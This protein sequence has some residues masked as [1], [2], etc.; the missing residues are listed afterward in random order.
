MA[1]YLPGVTDYIPNIQ[2][3]RP[4][5]NFYQ[6]ALETKEA[7][8]KA[9][10][11]KISGLYG[12]LLN[13]E[14]TRE[15]NKQK[16]E[17]FFKNVQND[18]QRMATVDLSLE[19]NVN[20]AYR[21]FQPIIDDK[22]IT[23]DIVYTKQYYNQKSKGQQ[24]KNCTDPKK[25]GDAKWW[26]EGDLEM[27]Y[28]RQ[29]YAEADDQTA[30]TMNAPAYTP[31][32]DVQKK[33]DAAAKE[34]GIEVQSVTHTRDG[35]NI[36]TTNGQQLVG[37]LKNY[38]T[39][40]IMNDPLAQGMY[41]TKA[42]LDRKNFSFERAQE[43]GSKEAAEKVYLQDKIRII[44]DAMEH[45]KKQTNVV[46]D[47]LSSQIKFADNKI[48]TE[49]IPVTKA[50]ETASAL[51]NLYAQIEANTAVKDHL[52]ATTASIE[53]NELLGLD[54]P[55]MIARVDAAV[56][57]ASLTFDMS[58]Y[59]QNYADLH[60]KVTKEADPYD[61][62]ARE[63]LYAKEMEELK[64]L[65]DKENIAFKYNLESGADQIGSTRWEEV[66]PAAGATGKQ[67]LEAI[68]RE[69]FQS[70][71]VQTRDAG[72]NLVNSTY[73]KLRSF[74]DNGTPAERESARLSL[75]SIFG[76]KDSKSGY[77]DENYKLKYA[78]IK[79]NPGIHNIKSY[80]NWENLYK[81]ALE[82]NK[83][84]SI[85]GV[86]LYTDQHIS[87]LNGLESN[88]N[89]KKKVRDAVLDTYNSDRGKVYDYIKQFGNTKHK[90]AADIAKASSSLNEFIEGYTK[91]YGDSYRKA[92]RDIVP[93]A[94]E[95]YEEIQKEYSSTYAEN[96]NQMLSSTR[97]SVSS[98]G[99]GIVAAG[100]RTLFDASKKNVENLNYVNSIKQD[101]ENPKTV[102]LSGTNEA[103]GA[104]DTAK[105]AAESSEPLKN[106][107]RFWLDQ[108]TNR[109]W[110]KGEPG[111]DDRPI[112]QVTYHDI[113]GSDANTAA[114]EFEFN[115]GWANKEKGTVKQPGTSA[116][117]FSEGVFTPKVTMYVDKSTA[118]NLM[119]LRSKPDDMDILVQN[120]GK[121]VVDN[122]KDF[123]G[124]VTI[125]KDANGLKA[126][127]TINYTDEDGSI[128]TTPLEERRANTNNTAEFRN[129]ILK[130]L[131]VPN[132]ANIAA[133]WNIYNAQKKVFSVEEIQ[134]MLQSNAQ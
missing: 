129:T 76:G 133:R 61:K 22:N 93:D 92:N 116:A 95:A 42:Y 105:L 31:F 128:K 35:Y 55:T 107:V 34:A 32:T 78:D 16:R 127:G 41:R 81:R 85:P 118:K 24:L 88:F 115:E 83:S 101:L 104:G 26:Q 97:P 84:N 18:I 119:Q 5:F 65:H 106:V 7:Q 37:P 27:D 70:Y 19:E 100:M 57:R 69:T 126:S 50:K 121:I 123:G 49:G 86:G 71:S 39:S 74:Y 53:D 90:D 56:A 131:E 30:L 72:L 13:A 33:L 36:T 12:M 99:G 38:F 130:I 52:E 23:H 46:L 134:Q 29:E 17:E 66:A 44:K 114:I 68:N 94:T 48:K 96:P 47:L 87:E 79:Q 45:P 67:N 59:A 21:V 6:K 82:N 98:G 9:G 112:A 20:A 43:Y 73:N 14:L 80:D 109:S 58:A 103:V 1:T 15:P 110:K 125:E 77:L 111:Y 124:V 117:L 64:D 113:A 3:F 89:F 25:C 11:D 102:V 2:P 10:Y 51:S 132:K 91:A 75:I 108:Y 60:K 54:V 40:I 122:Y 28:K 63:H 8:Y 4:D 120:G 62:M